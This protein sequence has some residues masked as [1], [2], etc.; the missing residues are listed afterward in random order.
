MLV[1]FEVENFRSFRDRQILSLVASPGKEHSTSHTVPS[2][3]S[4]T[5][6][7]LLS[8]AVYGANASG[9]SNL[10]LALKAM[11][12]VVVYSS[13]A[14]QRGDRIEPMEPFLFDPAMRSKPTEFEVTFFQDDVRY[15]YGFS[16][17]VERVVEE[18][19]YAF[20]NK[21]AQKWFHRHSD[22]AGEEVFDIGDKLPGPRK[23]V[24]DATRPNALFLSTAAQLNHEVL[25]SVFDWFKTTVVHIRADH[26]PPMS[27]LE[28]CEDE[29]S[30]RTVLNLMKASDIGID[31]FVIEDED[32]DADDLPNHITKL[33]TE[34]GRKILRHS[35]SVKFR[36]LGASSDDPLIDINNESSGTQR[37]FAMAGPIYDA[38]TNGKLLIVD[39]L[40]A[41]LHP[42]L[43][44][45]VVALF[46]DVKTNTE[47]AQL[48]FATH[49]TNLLTQDLMR[50][51]QF[52]FVE[53]DNSGASKLYP[54]TD[55]SPRKGR[56][57][58]S[59]NYLR[60]RYG[61]FP[62]TRLKP[63]IS[64]KGGE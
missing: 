6:R 5:D 2:P 31:D 59:E 46:H 19:L 35:P 22:E 4:P 50:R 51:D 41:S 14:S 11:R 37:L 27:T 25:G 52:W 56:E 33:F 55:F 29:E 53:K 20:P 49:D 36:H 23:V 40:S 7:L 24:K 60:G 16:A 15:Q 58:L 39:E 18:W 34:E 62:F 26:L 10:L 48:I 30:R 44:K 9:K 12:H 13:T 54:L 38:L 61:A 57:K 43:V 42:E 32:P 1:Q 47:S 8:A 17:T 45:S 63:V 21:R 28:I 3:E 64:S